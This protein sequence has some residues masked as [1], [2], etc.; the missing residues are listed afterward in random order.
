MEKG[1]FSSRVRKIQILGEVLG[2]EAILFS[3]V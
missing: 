2:K 3:S 1:Y